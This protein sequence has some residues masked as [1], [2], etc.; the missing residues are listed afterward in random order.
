MYL[1]IIYVFQILQNLLKISKL[2]PTALN[3]IYYYA[4]D[5]YSKLYV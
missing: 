3:I 1:Y 4:S 2:N 5:E